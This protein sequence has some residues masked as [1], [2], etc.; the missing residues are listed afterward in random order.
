M[1]ILFRDIISPCLLHLLGSDLFDFL[2]FVPLNF[3][4]S[5]SIA[6]VFFWSFILFLLVRAIYSSPAID[7][8]VAEMI[9]GFAFED[10]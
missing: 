1:K 9:G 5:M 4:P 7:S 2:S 8:G 10:P 3:P 6:S